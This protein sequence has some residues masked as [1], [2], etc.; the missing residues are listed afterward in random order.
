MS[1]EFTS[2]K[3]TTS[4]SYKGITPYKMGDIPSG[5]SL[6]IVNFDGN[7]EIWLV[8]GKQGLKALREYYQDEWGK[9]RSTPFQEFNCTSV[10][11]DMKAD[12]WFA[13]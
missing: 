7:L 12:K 5:L 1:I 2:Y 3:G 4:K 10:L 9:T 6:V 8:D 11:K 13:S